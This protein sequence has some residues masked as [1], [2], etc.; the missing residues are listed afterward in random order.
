MGQGLEGN[1]QS[2]QNT[3]KQTVS[4][5]FINDKNSPKNDN[6]GRVSAKMGQ[7]RGKRY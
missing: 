7:G 6:K 4:D 1:I 5:C 2:Y 3:D